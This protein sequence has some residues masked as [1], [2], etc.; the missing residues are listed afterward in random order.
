[1]PCR[2]RAWLTDPEDNSKIREVETKTARGCRSWR[3]GTRPG[4]LSKEHLTIENSFDIEV[5]SLT[6]G[7]GTLALVPSSTGQDH[8]SLL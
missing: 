4:D 6:F 5:H 8:I 2:P 1:M 3:E 7:K